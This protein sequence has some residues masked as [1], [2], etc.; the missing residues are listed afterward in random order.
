ML[1][2][3]TAPTIPHT[4]LGFRGAGLPGSYEDRYDFGFQYLMNFGII[5]HSI[6]VIH[7]FGRNSTACAIN[8]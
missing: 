3:L 4:G 6:N 8:G 5:H 7:A 1:R 2:V